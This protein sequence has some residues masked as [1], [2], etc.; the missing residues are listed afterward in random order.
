MPVFKVNYK[1]KLKIQSKFLNA[2][3]YC[4][5]IMRH[6]TMSGIHVIKPVSF[7]KTSCQILCIYHISIDFHFAFVCISCS[8]CILMNWLHYS[9]SHLCLAF[10]LH[11][12]VYCYIDFSPPHSTLFL[13]N[14]FFFG[15]GDYIVNSTVLLVHAY[16][17]WA[18][19]K[20]H[21]F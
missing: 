11:G 7:H 10:I 21:M 2:F 8:P 17:I 18:N 1:K 13:W 6:F 20:Y 5:L 4:A 12:C 19:Q 9:T 15:G 16:Y 14:L 3:Q